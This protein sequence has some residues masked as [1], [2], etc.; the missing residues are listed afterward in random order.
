MRYALLSCSYEYH[1][2]LHFSTTRA[3]KKSSGIILL[4]ERISNTSLKSI[5][6]KHLST[7][8]DLSISHNGM[9]D[10]ILSLQSGHVAHETLE[11]LTSCSADSFDNQYVKEASKTLCM[12][13]E[14]ASRSMISL[15]TVNLIEVKSL[16]G[17]TATNSNMQIVDWSK[18]TSVQA[19]VRQAS[20]MI[21]FSPNKTYLL[22]G[23]T[24]D[25]GR[26]MCKWMVTRGA[27]H[28]VLTSRNPKIVPKWWLDQLSDMGAN[29]VPM[30]MDVTSKESI[31]EV[32]CTIRRE[33]PPLGGVF[34]GALVITDTIFSRLT[35]E[36]LLR[37]IAPKVD[38]SK[39]LDELYSTN[40]LD[41]FIMFGSTGGMAG[42][43]AQTPYCVGN[44]YMEDV[45]RSRRAR[46][47]VGSILNSGLIVGV[48][49]VHRDEHREERSIKMS[50]SAC[51]SEKDVH[52]C[53]AECIIA[54]LPESHLSPQVVAGA[55]P[56]DPAEWD[57]VVCKSKSLDRRILYFKC[58]LQSRGL[59]HAQEPRKVIP[60]NAGSLLLRW[61][62]GFWLASQF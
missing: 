46:G 41:F 37:G 5:L 9:C 24:G 30:P 49:V 34:N 44:V 38:G 11:S 16:S 12:A 27:R 29:I 31:L 36:D 45:I 21:Y 62:P 3:D 35:Y 2:D 39:F 6:P 53:F 58:E 22:I 40:D 57:E 59:S 60:Q 15:Q 1:L 50:G 7:V 33:M 48:G 14:L 19:K 25:L 61:F 28:V 20:S 18:A 17:K 51:L 32:D 52:E 10:R 13:V 4:H 8:I 26:S 42:H 43:P 23:L 54:G 55:S 56:R 47:L